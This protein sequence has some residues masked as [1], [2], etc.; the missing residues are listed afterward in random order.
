MTFDPTLFHLQRGVSGAGGQLSV[1][2]IP[3][4]HTHEAK[5]DACLHDGGSQVVLA[6]KKK[7]HSKCFKCF[8]CFKCVKKKCSKKGGLK[9]HTHA[10]CLPG[11]EFMGEEV[12]LCLPASKKAQKH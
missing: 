6:C 9:K 10:E 11:R 3:S 2:W 4:T 12:R 1:Y 5:C 8:K 7:K